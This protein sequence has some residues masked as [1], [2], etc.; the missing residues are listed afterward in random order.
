MQ[1][2]IIIFCV[3]FFWWGCDLPRDTK[4]TF[5]KAKKE[6]LHVGVV[7]RTDSLSSISVFEKN[8]M[9]QFVA[10]N[11]LKVS[12]NH[13]TET[14]LVKQLEKDKIDIIIGGFTEKTLWKDK[15]ALTAPYD[16]EHVWLVKKG[17]NRLVFEIEKFF[18]NQ[19]Q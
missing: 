13:S 1:K 3:L 11:N 16:K 18:Y 14:Q 4:D 15:A 7:V 8:L 9:D 2:F 17:E 6:S 12:Y 10:A 19:M 5:E